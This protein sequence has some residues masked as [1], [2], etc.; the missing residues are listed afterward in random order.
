MLMVQLACVGWVP[1]EMDHVVRGGA[2]S[3]REVA[4]VVGSAA[5]PAALTQ[6]SHHR[7][8][9]PAAVP[10]GVQ[11]AND[12]HCLTQRRHGRTSHRQ[13][14]ACAAHGW[15]RLGGG[16]LYPVPCTMHPVPCHGWSRLGG[17]GR[18]VHGLS[19]HGLSVRGGCRR[20][21]LL[22]SA[23][24]ACMLH[25]S[26]HCMHILCR[27]AAACEHSQSAGASSGEACG[28]VR[29]REQMDGERGQLLRCRAHLYA[30]MHACMHAYMYVCMVSAAS[31]CVVSSAPRRP[32]HSSPP[33]RQHHQCHPRRYHQ[34]HPH[35]R[36]ARRSAWRCSGSHHR[37]RPPAQRARQ[38]RRSS[39][40]VGLVGGRG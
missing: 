34:C 10:H 36:S 2:S 26:Q 24:A 19:V 14:H 8:N 25:P 21:R 7:A 29:L 6:R 28:S 5:E 17:D 37:R 11:T 18:S 13:R 32:P 38:R 9:A 1:R 3:S 22:A 39:R 23:L 15:S 20:C 40:A 12:A 35:V 4:A 33:P 27:R 31:S 16:G 30:C